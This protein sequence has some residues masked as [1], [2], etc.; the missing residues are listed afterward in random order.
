DSVVFCNPFHYGDAVFV[1][2]SE[3]AVPFLRISYGENE[4]VGGL[5]SLDGCHH[6]MG[7][8]V[9]FPIAEH[10]QRSSAAFISQLFA[11]G[12]E[13]RVVKR[14]AEIATFVWTQFRETS[15]IVPVGVEL[16]QH[17]RARV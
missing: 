8:G 14:S 12:V 9:V 11:D 6:V 3:P 2:G 15:I 5:G 7:T 13:N 1:A 16:L 4:N 17:L 10:K